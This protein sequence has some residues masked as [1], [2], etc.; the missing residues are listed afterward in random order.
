MKKILLALG[1]VCTIFIF[2]CSAANTPSAAA[3]KF[4][5]AVEKNDTKMMEQY[6]TP[7]TVRIV[8]TFVTKIQVDMASK[9][10][11]TSFTETID[12]ENPEKAT[13]SVKFAD[14]YET[15]LNMVKVNDKWKV[16]IE[17]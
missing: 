1:I 17:K 8:A 13:V 15:S 12:P 10:K 14:N 11:V 16:D 4:Y 9:G 5:E 3:K 2:A 6:A 7:E